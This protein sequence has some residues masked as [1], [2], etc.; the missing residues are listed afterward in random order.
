MKLPTHLDAATRERIR[1][2]LRGLG[3]LVQLVRDKLKPPQ[4]PAHP[5]PQRPRINTLPEPV[6]GQ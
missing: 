6:Q 1:A 5:S 2:E 3:L 4:A